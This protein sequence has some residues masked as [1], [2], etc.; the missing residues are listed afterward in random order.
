LNTFVQSDL[1]GRTEL[2]IRIT[3]DLSG[4]K[5]YEAQIDGKWALF[6][7]DLKNDVLIYRFDPKRIEKGSKH[8]LT[9]K[10]FDN[11]NNINEFTTDF[12]W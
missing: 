8:I 1:S 2:R 12:R 11:K 4:I 7:Y 6:E 5:G 10:V 3:D 9:L